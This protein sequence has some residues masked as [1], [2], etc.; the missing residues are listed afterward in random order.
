MPVKT[1]IATPD[2]TEI[3]SPVLEGRAVT[4]GQHLLED[5]S[6]VLLPTSSSGKASDPATG[7]KEK[8][9]T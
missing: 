3:L 2:L 4:L 5:G 1:G 9:G 7:T 8:S 6:P